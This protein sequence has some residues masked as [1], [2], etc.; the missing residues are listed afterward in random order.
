M[1]TRLASF[2]YARNGQIPKDAQT[3]SSSVNSGA[4]TLISPASEARAYIL[5]RN[6]TG[7]T[8]RYFYNVGDYAVGFILKPQDTVRIVNKK[9]VYVQSESSTG[10]ICYDIGVG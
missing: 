1:S 10:N 2:P 3:Y 9:A 4:P 5:L 6:T 8:I 7:S